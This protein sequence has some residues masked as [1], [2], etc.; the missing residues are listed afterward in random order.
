M[1]YLSLSTDG[2]TAELRNYGITDEQIRP[3]IIIDYMSPKN[4]VCQ[5]GVLNFYSEIP[6]LKRF[7]IHSFLEVQK[8]NS[9]LKT[10]FI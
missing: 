8:N 6:P 9:G 10:A 2:I 3:S 4:V 5:K 7:V 1:H